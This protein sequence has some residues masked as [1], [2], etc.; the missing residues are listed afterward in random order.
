MFLTAPPNPTKAK[1]VVYIVV[2]IVLGVFISYL[3]HAGIEAIYLAWADSTGRLVHW[4]GSCALHPVLQVGLVVSGA[5]GGFFLGKYW[6]RLVYVE[7]K[8]AKG[9][10]DSKHVG[11]P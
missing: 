7:R 2:T 6:W 11:A 4:Y 8:W 5:V 10:S 9:L 1:H 3:I